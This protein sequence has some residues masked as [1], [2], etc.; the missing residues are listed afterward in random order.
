MD[1]LLTN[2]TSDVTVVFD[3]ELNYSP[4]V[5][6]TSVDSMQMTLNMVKDNVYYSAYVNDWSAIN[7]LY[8]LKKGSK[9]SM[10]GSFKAT[11]MVDVEVLKIDPA[12]NN[13]GTSRVVLL[14][15]HIYVDHSNADKVSTSVT[16]GDI[17]GEMQN[18]LGK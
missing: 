10:A 17:L 13:D 18:L 11:V 15:E 16:A 2:L 4:K 14:V 9:I 5:F 8:S 12:A 1:S 7:R 3:L 6:L